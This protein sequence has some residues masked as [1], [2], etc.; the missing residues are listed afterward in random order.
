[1]VENYS[2]QVYSDRVDIKCFD[3]INFIKPRYSLLLGTPSL[4]DDKFML[5]FKL[6]NKQNTK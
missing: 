2:F 1:M 4:I 3:C 6:E 5:V